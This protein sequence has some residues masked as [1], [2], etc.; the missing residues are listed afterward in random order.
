MKSL[1]FA[2]PDDARRS[3]AGVGLALAMLLPALL[4]PLA[5]ASAAPLFQEVSQEEVG[6][7]GYPESSR[8][9]TLELADM[10]GLLTQAPLE[11]FD[12]DVPGLT[13]TLPL[14]GESTEQF[15]VWE[16][17]ILHPEL[18]AKFPEIRT[19]VGRGVQDPTATVRLDTTPAGFHAMILSTRRPMFIDPV[20]RG[21]AQSYVSYFKRDRAAVTSEREEPFTCEVEEDPEVV[22]EIQ[23]LVEERARSAARFTGQQLR[24]YRTAIAATGEYTAFHGGTVVAGMAAITTSLNRVTGIYERELSVRMELVPNN[25]LLVYTNAGSDPYTNGSGGTMLGQN[26][27]NLDS[28]IGSANYDI[29]HVFSTGGGGIAGLGVVCRTGNKARGVTGRGSPIGDAFDVDYVAHEMGHQYGGSHTFNGNAGS[30]SGNRTGS[31]AYEPGS[32]STIQAYAGICGSQNIANNSGA[33]FHSRSFDQ[34]TAYT[35]SGSGSGCPVVT[36]TGNLPPVPVAG[37]VG[38]TI[39][40]STP[41]VLYG[42]I[43]DPDGDTPTYCWEQ[44]DLGPAGAPDSPSGNAPIFRSFFPKTDDFRLFPKNRDIR[45]NTHTIGELLPTYSRTLNFRLTA[46]DNLGGVDWDATSV[47]VDD[48]A[49]P[50]LVTSIGA[51]PWVSGESRTITW[52]VAGTDLAPVSCATVNI[53][54]STDD[55]RGFEYDVPLALGVP[56]DGSEVV[57]VPSLSVAE[58]RVIVEAA[59]NIFFD[60][61]DDPFV[62]L[63]PTGVA[64]VSP[65]IP[66]STLQVGPNPFRDRTSISYSVTRHG[67]VAVD[68]F[69][70]AGRR[71]ETL[72]AGM[73]DPGTHVVEWN[74]RDLDGSPV[75][76]GI[77][78]VRMESEGEARMARVVHLK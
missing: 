27:S 65:E 23:R 12:A 66:T 32:G 37:N 60:L 24:T 53:R 73:S 14:P 2:A 72:Y 4:L 31:S 26:Q 22:A 44:Y 43:T 5:S 64:S 9:F 58:G 39:P 34:M 38:H 62:I 70:A 59:D 8:Y 29:G 77:Y 52:D 67:R 36:A 21:D 57:S 47:D 25:D 56:N 41:F 28:V 68:I 15:T 51:T 55:G 1:Q 10:R 45:T 48:S 20:R 78:F 16:S 13:V 75:A 49:G 69:S 6:A 11:R 46:R 63:I 3:I 42:S 33:Y 71:I 17:S 54:L 40:I 19:Y 74:G 50:F 61:N 76:S 30:C 35:Q 7:V 18:A